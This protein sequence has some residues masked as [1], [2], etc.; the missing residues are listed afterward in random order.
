MNDIEQVYNTLPS[1]YLQLTKDYI[2]ITE[3]N[4][5]GRLLKHTSV[6]AFF[7]A[8]LAHAKKQQD[9]LAHALEME[10]AKH[11]ELR[12]SEFLQQGK[13]ATEASL[14]GYVYTVREINELRDKSFDVQHKY[15]LAKNLMSALDHQKDM[16]VQMSANRRAEAKMITDLN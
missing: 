7:G 9:K 5:E 1:T 6:F 13:K 16:L 14:N 12:R 11:K 8:V 2:D 3:S 10:E 4:V 15:N